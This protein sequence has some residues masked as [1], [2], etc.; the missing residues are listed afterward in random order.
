MLSFKDLGVL[1]GLGVPKEFF[2]TTVGPR[3]LEGGR[4][5]PF[6]GRFLARVILQPPKKQLSALNATNPKP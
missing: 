2:P 5:A 4:C 3:F 6:G 1:S